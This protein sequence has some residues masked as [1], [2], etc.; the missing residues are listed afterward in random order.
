MLKLQ[1]TIFWKFFKESR[2]KR[3]MYF[4]SRRATKRGKGG[5]KGKPLRG[6]TYFVKN[7]HLQILKKR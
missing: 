4:H 1:T 7:K 6:K 3:K 5:V 2:K